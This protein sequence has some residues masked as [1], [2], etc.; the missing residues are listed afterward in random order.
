MGTFNCGYCASD[1]MSAFTLSA[2]KPIFD[3]KAENWTAQT[4]F[5]DFKRKENRTKL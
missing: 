3:G 1:I 4:S 5:D 2:M